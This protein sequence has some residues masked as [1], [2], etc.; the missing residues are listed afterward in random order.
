MYSPFVIKCVLKKN[1]PQ[2]TFTQKL[3]YV[4][5]SHPITKTFC[6]ICG[7]YVIAVLVACEMWD[8]IVADPIIGGDCCFVSPFVAPEVTHAIELT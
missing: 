7:I 5:Q 2:R 4:S 1:V 8:E 3:I 6:I